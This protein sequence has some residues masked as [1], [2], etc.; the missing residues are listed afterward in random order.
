MTPV[1]VRGPSIGRVNVTVPFG[2]F[3]HCTGKVIVRFDHDWNEPEHVH[4]LS[5][6][7]NRPFDIVPLI[8]IDPDP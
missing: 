1:A 8:E 4:V 6:A 5:V 7:E 3:V 2:P